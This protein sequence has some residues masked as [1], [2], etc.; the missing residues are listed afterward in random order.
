[1]VGMRNWWVCVLYFGV[2]GCGE[3]VHKQ[4]NPDAAIDAPRVIDAEIDAPPTGSA[5]LTITI[6][7][8]GLGSV[9]SAPAGINC[10]AA[11]VYSFPV[12]MP[13]MLTAMPATG[14]TVSWNGGG[15]TGTN[16]Q[17]TITLTANTTITL[18]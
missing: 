5:M 4:P 10:G 6:S 1:M 12:N 14:G 3:V 18:G 16:P 8:N 17:C 2:V 11:C 13:I 15:C 9:V 7:G